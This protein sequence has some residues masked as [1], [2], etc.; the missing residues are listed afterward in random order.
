MLQ[1]LLCSIWVA[2]LLGSGCADLNVLLSQSGYRGQKLSTDEVISGLKE[3]LVIGAEHSVS[4]AS[5]KDGF[6]GNPLIRIPF[7]PEAI[8]VKNTLEK[9]GFTNLVRDFE[10]SLNRAAEEAVKQSLPIFKDAVTSMTITDAMGILKGADNAATVYLRAK[11]EDALMRA[12]F[13]IARD[14]VAK[15]NVTGYWRP[16]ASVYNQAAIITGGQ[17]VDPDLE[18]YIT[19]K[20][21][22]GLFLLIAGEEENI[23]KNPAA[24]ITSILKRVFGA[25]QE[26]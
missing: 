11:T 19:E 8:T 22:D 7:P 24:R 5:V 21:L 6:Y 14:A 10:E 25:H 1:K 9:A 15:V 20:S 23:R 18:K 12:F 13:P 2:A 4:S 17:R 26:P 3:A 16:V